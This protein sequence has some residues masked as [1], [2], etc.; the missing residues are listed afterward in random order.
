MFD[1]RL[2]SV[3][4]RK[5]IAHLPFALI[6]IEKPTQISVGVCN[7]HLNQARFSIKILVT[8]KVFQVQQLKVCNTSSGL[9]NY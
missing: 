9:V 6:Y 5:T 2:S 1:A 7:A 3:Q 8:F 4:Q